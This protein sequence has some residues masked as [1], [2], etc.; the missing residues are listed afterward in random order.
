[1]TDQQQA[2]VDLATKL[3]NGEISYSTFVDELK[4]LINTAEEIFD[5]NIISWLAG[6]IA[7]VGP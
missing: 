1:M 7:K 4:E 3:G 2:F 6:Q 5:T